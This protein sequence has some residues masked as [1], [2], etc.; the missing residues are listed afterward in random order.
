MID[1]RKESLFFLSQKKQN[2]LKFP[3]QSG[4]THQGTPSITDKGIISPTHPTVGSIVEV[5][6]GMCTL[7]R[8]SSRS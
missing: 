7:M 1:K 3:W 4:D 5:H 8:P 2:G 6:V